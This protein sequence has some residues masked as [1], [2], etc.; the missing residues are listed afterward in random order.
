MQGSEY[1]WIWL[2]N[3]LWQGSE[4]AWS[5][6]HGVLNKIRVLNI[7]GLK[8]W[9]GREYARVTQTAEYAWVSLNMP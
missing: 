8:L 9:E 3:G 7:P 5:M 2:N 6:F 1:A 4:F